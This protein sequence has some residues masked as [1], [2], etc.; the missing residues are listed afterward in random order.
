MGVPALVSC[1][2]PEPKAV[3]IATIP[4]TSPIATDD[5]DEGRFAKPPPT[6][7]PTATSVAT[8]TSTATS[9][10]PPPPPPPIRGAWTVSFPLDKTNPQNRWCPSGVAQCALSRDVPQ[11]TESGASASLGCPSIID[12]P[13]TCS[14]ADVRGCA[15]DARCQAPFMASV[16][17]RER[18]QKAAA[19]CYEMPRICVPPN[20]G[21]LLRV[22]KRLVSADVEPRGD[23]REP[24]RADASTLSARDR[25]E[26]AARWRAAAQAEHASI[27]SFSRVSLQ[28]MAL[29]AP[30]DLLAAVH[31]AALDEI[32]HARACFAL[33]S[34][35]SG[36]DE[37][38][39]ALPVQALAV[40]A[41]EL[42][43]LARDTFI[44]ACVGE[45]IGTV[46]AR[47]A[48]ER[49]VEPAVRDALE[50]I[51]RDEERHA[52]LA[53]RTAAWAAR[54]GGAR[55]KRALTEALLRLDEF[56]PD[57]PPSEG[58]LGDH[59]VLPRDVERDLRRRAIEEIVV[60]CV[61]A[62]IESPGEAPAP[63]PEPRP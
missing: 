62:L 47:A 52:E 25:G 16:T 19:C 2:K 24:A 49:A 51:A 54:A 9:D 23:W 32:A 31:A 11:R 14:P 39:G 37:G 53:W 3:E 38:P 22:G 41:V 57:V 58:D 6:A 18:S 4:T 28:M 59:G 63:P 43:V 35:Y 34:S 46:T 40:K 42:D 1:S 21:R 26:L 33:A 45:T 8:P 27:A 56:L 5:P 17:T 48:A 29:G 36:L 15:P 55:V 12:V 60:P 13:C 10:G 20:V 30:A 7:T 50:R 44:D 61:R